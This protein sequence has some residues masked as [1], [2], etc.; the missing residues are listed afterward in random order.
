MYC[1]LCG[2]FLHNK[3][4]EGI[5]CQ[6]CKYDVRKR[7]HR[8]RRTGCREQTIIGVHYCYRCGQPYRPTDLSIQHA[9]QA[10]ECAGCVR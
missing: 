10:D 8:A 5:V 7:E 4:Q 6:D 3:N 2:I 1:I 9:F